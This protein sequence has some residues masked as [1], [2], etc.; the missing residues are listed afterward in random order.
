MSTNEYI[1]IYYVYMKYGPY[2]LYIYF[3]RL[4]LCIYNIYMY[5]QT[6]KLHST[7][8]PSPM[9]VAVKDV[10]MLVFDSKPQALRGQILRGDEGTAGDDAISGG[11]V[12]PLI[13]P[14][15]P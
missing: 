3:Y 9:F 6:Y 13:L 1:C 7:A 2:I 12:I 4:Y 14:K 11:V 15:V 5:Y 10:S 8:A